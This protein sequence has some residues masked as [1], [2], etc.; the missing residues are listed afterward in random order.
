MGASETTRV[1]NLDE[2]AAMAEQIAGELQPG[3]V[4][5]LSGDLGSGK[6]TF[7]QALAKSLG[8]IDV[9]TSPTFT[10]VG[11][12]A[13]DGTRDIQWLV[14]I[15]LY[16]IPAD[17]HGVDRPYIA[18]VIDTAEAN[19]RVV[20]VEWPEKLELTAPHAWRLSFTADQEQTERTII[21]QKP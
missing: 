4:L 18:E 16:R 10:I 15:D 11:E 21:V 12:Y 8:V 13:T 1:K 9:V 14:H 6:T 2:L 19:K 3:A 5:L 7:T 20:V 17:Q